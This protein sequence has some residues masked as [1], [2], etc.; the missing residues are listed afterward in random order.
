MIRV[1]LLIGGKKYEV[2]KDLVNWE[3]VEISIK[4]K[5]F[6]GV[7]RTFGDS[8]EFAGNSYILL[9]NEFL[10]N[11]LSAS[12]VIVIGVL[13]NS[14]TYNEK[15]RCN[16]DFSSYQNNGNTISIKA[17]DNST[18][19][20]INANKSQ[21]YDIPVSSLKSDELYYDR[22]E[23]NNSVEFYLSPDSEED[24]EGDRVGIINSSSIRMSF[25]LGY[26]TINFPVKNIIDVGDQYGNWDA[27]DSRGDGK[28]FIRA[29]TNKT[30]HVE[31]S[32]LGKA[33]FRD[34]SNNVWI[35]QLI[36]WVGT[37]GK[38][39]Y[40]QRLGENEWK[41]IDYSAEIEVKTKE[42]LS[43]TIIRG[44]IASPGEGQDS[45]SAV[46]KISDFKFYIS[47]IG[48]N[49]PVNFDVFTPNKLLTSI[50][51]NMGL[52]DMTGE[53]KEGD[54]TI[55][56]MIAA[57]SIR[58]IK[59][60]KVHTS[61]SKFSEWAKACLG[62]Y[63]KIEGKK[64]IFCHLTE[65]YD[66]E[67]V[68]ELE[69]VNSIDISIDNSLIYSGVDV[70]YEKKDYDE[71]NG[72]DEFHVKNSFST[73]ISINDNIYK[74]I[75]PYRA[76][77]YGIEFL[78]QKRDEETKDDSS[79]NDLFIVDA[80]S[81][82]DPSTSSIKLKLNRQGDRPSG[83][84]FPSSVFNVAY[85]PRRMLL[86][87]KEILSSCTS[88]LE[89]TASEGNA[90]AVL[91]RESENSPVV[92]DS[93]Y[94]R[95]ETLKVGTIGLSPFPVLYDGLISFDYNNKK[96]TGYVSDITEHLGKMQTTDYTLIC[97]NIV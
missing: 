32:F 84:L 3:D 81:V 91:W 24:E 33:E 25:P 4:R 13:N 51:S 54:T 83:V 15:I 17:I 57:E 58:N 26:G 52:T 16:L 64:V 42:E 21:V 5:D 75:S 19:A 10:T 46:I 1:Q 14:W 8:F 23:L 35:V 95:V 71:I 68:K 30:I 2:T 9:E 44:S 12:A 6:G 53:V 60:A 27:Y 90:D 96:Y 28:F 93:R 49:K 97:K 92:L 94:F 37:N 43:L 72:R 61:F 76:D 34:T 45:D 18:E 63:Y 77:C 36:K 88:R 56:Y 87:N 7:Y 79:D 40:E 31:F 73:G 38:V 89:F 59:N 11:Y 20:I 78:A 29:N 65:L 80:I 55:P 41:N 74:L 39:I 86:A 85:S 62:Y 69:H 70:G 47:Y 66:P 50:L 22:M 82:L 67:T 48:R